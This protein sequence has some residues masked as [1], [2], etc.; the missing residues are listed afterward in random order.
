MWVTYETDKQQG[1]KYLK[2][3]K[4]QAAAQEKTI[5]HVRKLAVTANR[6]KTTVNK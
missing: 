6:Q 3:G 2:R 4:M 1:M 5:L